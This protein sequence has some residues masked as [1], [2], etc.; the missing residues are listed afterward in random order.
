MNKKTLQ[1]AL[2]HHQ[3][4]DF[5]A[6]E[7]IYREIL[8]D[9]PDQADIWHLMGILFAQQQKF[10]ESQ[11][12]IE[13]AVKLDPKNPAYEN[14]L[15]NVF[16]N[17]GNLDQ[18]SNHYQQALI[19]A[20][21]YAVAYNNLAIIFSQQKKD[22]EA[23]KC[24]RQAL[25]LQPSYTD[26]H[27]NLAN[28]L[29]KQQKY[30]EAIKHYQQAITLEP[31]HI[32]AHAHLGQILQQ[33]EQLEEAVNHYQK[34]L[35]Y[36]ENH[37]MTQHNLA[38]VL[39]KQGRMD[40]ATEHFLKTLQLDPQHAEALHNLG[41]IYLLINKP[42]EALK[43]FLRLA[44]LKPDAEVY[45]NIGTLYMQLD[46]HDDAIQYLQEALKLL[47]NNLDTYLNLAAAYLKKEDIPNAT[48]YYQAAFKL[49]PE[50]K[51]IKYILNAL[52]QNEIP[53]AA[54]NEYLQHLFDQYAPYFEKHL[55][56]LDYRVPDLLYNAIATLKLKNQELAILDLGCGTGLA[57]EKFRP[58]AK[59][60][61]GID[62]SSKMIEVAANKHL[63]DELKVTDIK[64][65]LTDFTELD[66]ILAADVFTYIGDL[67]EIFSKA[68]HALNEKGYFAFTTEKTRHY[69]YTLQKSARYAHANK[70]IKKLAK[71]NHFKILKQ[72]EVILRKQKN[73]P[74]EG[75]LYLLQK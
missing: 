2:Q 65:A 9:N 30:A 70:Y 18:A 59:K 42:N 17:L 60:L 67:E 33:Q 13:K 75:Y 28:L 10:K 11:E 21:T 48:K 35:Q 23:E 51:E 22:Q 39:V 50:D 43:Y 62:I 24:Y 41:T 3:A 12:F 45:Y 32:E 8:A 64:Q 37:I 15:G 1:I 5:A 36:D 55:Q 58:L 31:E 29:T 40:E 57:G 20:P 44:E 16:K 63:Y 69:P 61:I 52:E 47:P 66:L 74:V 34:V 26:A 54:P 49:K 14:S 73:H 72:D 68:Y 46:R 71:N 56:F 4:G 38:T 6:A 53:E 25:Q 7:K 27:Y 19:L